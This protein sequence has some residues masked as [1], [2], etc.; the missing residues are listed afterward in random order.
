M[1]CLPLRRANSVTM[2]ASISTSL[3]L[4]MW[5]I[6]RE[7]YQSSWLHCK[8]YKCFQ[9]T[10]KILFPDFSCMHRRVCVNGR[11]A[12]AF[13][14]FYTPEWQISLP[15]HILQL[16]KSLPVKWL[17]QYVCHKEVSYI[18]RFSSIYFTISGARN[19]IHYTEDLIRGVLN[20]GAIRIYLKPKWG[21][22]FG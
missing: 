22:P 21:T 20:R 14:H 17:T 2:A 13:G 1:K 18:S 11:Y 5:R 6:A 16:V 4:C 19:I 9:E 8:W 7:L 12:P 10:R 15:F 3:C